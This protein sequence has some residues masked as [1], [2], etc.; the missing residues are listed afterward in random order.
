MPGSKIRKLVSIYRR[1]DYVLQSKLLYGL[2]YFSDFPLVKRKRFP[3]RNVAES[4]IACA[5]IA[6]NHECSRAVSPALRAVWAHSAAA[7]C[8]EVLF[9]KQ[10]HHLTCLKSSRQFYLKPFRLTAKIG[11]LILLIHCHNLNLSIFHGWMMLFFKPKE[12]CLHY[13]TSPPNKTRSRQL[14]ANFLVDLRHLP[15]KINHL[16]LKLSNQ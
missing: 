5:N 7:Y 14:R 4:A 10:A 2:H 9:I 6:S 13:E 11:F 12:A 3:G 8:M 16:R 15:C 1:D